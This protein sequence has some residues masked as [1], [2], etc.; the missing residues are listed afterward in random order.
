M[1]CHRLDLRD[2]GGLCGPGDLGGPGGV[3][4]RP[5]GGNGVGTFHRGTDVP[6]TYSGKKDTSQ[7]SVVALFDFDCKLHE[8]FKESTKSLFFI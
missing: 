8:N 6:G 5:L 2:R 3:P 4:C 7:H 1:R